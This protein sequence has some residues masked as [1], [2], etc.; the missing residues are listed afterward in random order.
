M[1]S[2]SSGDREAVRSVCQQVDTQHGAHSLRGEVTDPE[3]GATGACKE[4]P[5]SEQLP[6]WE[7]TYPCLSS[8]L[9]YPASH[10]RGTGTPT[11]RCH[12]LSM[13]CLSASPL[14]LRQWR[15]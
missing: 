6:D 9:G 10:V 11:S 1:P 14:P 13:T 8:S 4:S 3:D 7:H 2:C 15:L 5:M 12:S